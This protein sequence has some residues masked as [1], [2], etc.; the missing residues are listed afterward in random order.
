MKL[1]EFKQQIREHIIE[2]LSE[3]EDTAKE[4]TSI[5][6]QKKAELAKIEA[7]KEKIANLQKGVNESEELEEAKSPGTVSIIDK[8]TAAAVKANFRSKLAGRIIDH[9]MN[10]EGDKP[11]T[12]KQIALDLGYKEQPSVNKIIGTLA[13]AGVL[14]ITGAAPS[15]PKVK[16]PKVKMVKPKAL[17]IPKDETPEDEKDTWYKSDE[18]DKTPKSKIEPSIASKKEIDALERGFYDDEDEDF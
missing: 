4:K 11:L 13:D 5:E 8:E 15:E 3:A 16:E 14:K 18:D 9:I 2:I 12:K 7:S 17:S 10:Y 1:S 6:Q